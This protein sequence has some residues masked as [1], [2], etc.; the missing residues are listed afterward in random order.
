MDRIVTAT[1]DGQAFQPDA[2]LDLQPNTRYFLTIQPAPE[3][4]S[5]LEGDAWDLL[6]RLAGTIDAP[7]DWSIQHDHYIH[8]TPKRMTENHEQ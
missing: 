3:S 6:K 8:G 1:F 5:E 7:E 2:P 4:W